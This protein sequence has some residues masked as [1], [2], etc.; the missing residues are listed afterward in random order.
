MPILGDPAGTSRPNQADSCGVYEDE[1]WIQLIWYKK[2][3]HWPDSSLSESC[4]WC[5]WK[6]CL[7]KLSNILVFKTSGNDR[8]LYREK[9]AGTLGNKGSKV[10]KLDVKGHYFKKMLSLR[11]K[12]H[13][14]SKARGL[15]ITSLSD[16]NCPQNCIS[17]VCYIKP[18]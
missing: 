12:L 13:E 3:L 18:P 4:P 16:Q 14:D 11:K 6:I 9:E 8:Y 17:W 2:Y 10:L 5:W 15:T 7:C 1:S